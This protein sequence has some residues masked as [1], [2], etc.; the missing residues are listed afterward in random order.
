[1]VLDDFQPMIEDISDEVLRKRYLDFVSIFE[2][3]IDILKM[4]FGTSDEILNS[5]E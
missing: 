4:K 5:P 1:M 2:V 3:S